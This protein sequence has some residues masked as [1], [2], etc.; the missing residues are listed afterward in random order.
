MADAVDSCGAPLQIPGSEAHRTRLPPV[1]CPV[2]LWVMCMSAGESQNLPGPL[3]QAEAAYRRAAALLPVT[4]AM[5]AR[6]AR[7][8]AADVRLSRVEPQGMRRLHELTAGLGD[9]PSLRTLLPRVLD[10]ALALLGADFGTLQL[11]DPVTGSLRL[12]TQSGFDSGFLEYFAVVDDGHS[13]CGR[14]AREAAQTVIA[15]VNADPGF[16]PHRGIAA[17]SG[18]RAVQS[19]PLADDAGHLIG[20]VSTHFRCPYHPP[21][22]DLRI[23]ELYADVAGDA[24]AGRLGA[25]DEG[26][27]DPTGRTVIPAPLGLGGGQEPGT[28]EL[29]GWGGDWRSRER[30]PAREAASLEDAMS[31][32]AGYIVNRLFSVGLSLESARSIVEK[33]PA[34]DRVAAA[35]GEVDRMIGDIRTVLFSLAA[36]RENHA[37]GRVPAPPGGY[38]D[39]TGELLGGVINSVSEVGALLR[40][41]ADLP[42]TARLRITEALRRLDDA[43]QKVRDHVSAERDRGTQPGPA[44][45][46]P[47]GRQKRSAPSSDHAALL[48]ERMAP[49]ARALQAAAVDYAALLE[50]Q[51]ALIRQPGRMDYPAEVKRWRAFADQA[52][53]MAERWEQTP[54]P[55]APPDTG[56]RSR[57]DPGTAQGVRV[58]TRAARMSQIASTT[59]R[60]NEEGHSR[61][62][63]RTWICD[64]DTRELLGWSLAEEYGGGV[65]HGP[66][67]TKVV[68]RRLGRDG[69]YA[70]TAA[71]PTVGAWTT[72]RPRRM[73]RRGDGTRSGLDATPRMLTRRKPCGGPRRRSPPRR[74]ACHLPR[75]RWPSSAPRRHVA[76]DRSAP[77]GV[78]GHEK[79]PRRDQPEQ[80]LPR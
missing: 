52:E 80:G 59:P 8:Y 15:D 14:A 57:L 43:V 20:V 71:G 11:F 67:G 72:G 47:L 61:G 54:E 28:A 63:A 41:T 17:A 36:D 29:P 62:R 64:T 51:A 13:A 44:W 9:V 31:Q 23:M 75:P 69:H 6:R 2:R 49:A 10:G 60:S 30:G 53:Q 37:P 39:R 34:G 21:G 27:A 26:P 16:A 55:E 22:P 7:H 12:V 58:C 48:Q 78:R 42:D 25:P 33:G 40:A 70:V 18:F 45:R 46:P 56:P 76:P 73:R 77:R 1:C 3:E 79:V 19:T 35:T 4:G 24:I 5:I 65:G 66:F 74:P 32:F 50:Q 68:P 38:A